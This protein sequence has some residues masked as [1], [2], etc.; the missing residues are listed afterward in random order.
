MRLLIDI[1]SLLEDQPSGVSQ[2]TENLL[3]NLL[4]IDQQNQ[5]FL[6][7]NCW[8]AEKRNNLLN[9]YPW[10]A[11]RKGVSLKL[12][13]Y[14]NKLFNS[15]VNFLRYP[16]IDKLVGGADLFFAPNLQFISVSRRC[17]KVI[18]VHDLS[19]EI[20]PQFLSERRKIWHT[21]IRPKKLLSQADSLIAVSANTQKDLR[22]IY[23]IPESKIK[24]IYPAAGPL[25]PEEKHLIKD[26]YIL[27]LA[28]FEPRKNLASL[29]LA[30]EKL[31]SQEKF[32]DY[33]LILAGA[34][35]W[36]T[37][38]IEKLIK[39]DQRVRVLGYVSEK[40]KAQL[41]RGA[42]VFV[43]PSFYEGFGMPPLEAMSAGTPVIAAAAGS[44]PEVLGS[45]ALYVQPQD[46]YD[47]AQ[48]L[49]DLL[50]S[51]QLSAELR[52]AGRQRAAQYTWSRTAAQT[53]EVF[54]KVV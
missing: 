42:A 54:K 4:Q 3:K 13:N 8:Q 18:T 21:I 16:Q 38:E 12:F 34:R 35:G 29:L 1:R 52:Q 30:F 32:K 17:R 50:S 7:A 51:P 6:F 49:A 45:A 53:L 39:K 43:Y 24:V 2:Y 5:Y 40:E 31:V 25:A 22:D 44:L 14:P 15:A 47:L 19:Y 41:L 37:A 9:K 23:Q 36:K 27:S 28:T 20:F 33:K 11:E 26:K 48:A 10:L 46:I